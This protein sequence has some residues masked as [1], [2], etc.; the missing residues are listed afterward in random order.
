MD[1]TQDLGNKDDN[2][3]A[4]KGR[5]RFGG[6]GSFLLLV[7]LAFVLHG[8]LFTALDHIAPI[9]SNQ[10]EEILLVVETPIEFTRI[11]ADAR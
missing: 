10:H 2:R 9:E 1:G 3:P 6:P 8:A 4:R 11:V 5:I 7:A